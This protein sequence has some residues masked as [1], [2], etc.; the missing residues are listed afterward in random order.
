MI[1]DNKALKRMER[2]T[3]FRTIYDIIGIT[4]DGDIVFR[5]FARNKRTAERIK[6]KHIGRAY[7][8]CVELVPK[9][10]HRF[11]FPGDVE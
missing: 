11:I 5:F 1:F 10:D 2:G 7:Y 4:K 9:F 6:R 8:V 3:L